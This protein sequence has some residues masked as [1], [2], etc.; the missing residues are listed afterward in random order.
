MNKITFPLLLT[1][2]VFIG[3]ATHPDNIAPSYVSEF[4]YM[5]YTQQQ[6]AAEQS[7]VIS[8]LSRATNAQ[9]KAR[10]NDT[11]GVIFLGLP[12]SSLSGSNQ[13]GEV[14]RLKGEL[15]AIQKAAA[16][17]GFNIPRVVI[18]EQK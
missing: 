12:V 16:S 6:L 4:S 7:R 5:H 17:K 14:A 15:E 2:L 3:C 9:R 10:S 13:A 1:C 8:A 18:E 11:L